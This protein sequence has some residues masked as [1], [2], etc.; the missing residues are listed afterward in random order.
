MN[1]SERQREFQ[2]WLDGLDE[3]LRAEVPHDL[4]ELTDEEFDDCEACKAFLE[5]FRK[6]VETCRNAPRP[7]P[8]RDELRAAAD[9]ARR[10]LEAKGIL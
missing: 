9:A 5:S 3:D 2:R 4:M 6:T 10:E 7:R 8:D 1:Q